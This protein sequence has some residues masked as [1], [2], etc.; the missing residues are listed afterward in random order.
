MAGLGEMSMLY[1]PSTRGFYAPGIHGDAVPADAVSITAARHRRLLALQAAGARISSGTDGRPRAQRAAGTRAAAIDAVKAEARRRIDAVA[2]L[3]R[4]LND[5]ADVPLMTA[6]QLL[7][8]D[9]RHA[10]IRAIRAA[11]DLIEA[12]IADMG[13]TELR[14]LDIA[15]DSRWPEPR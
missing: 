15:H 9:R 11:S 14:A 13:A 10:R 5:V 6:E 4:Q 1:S 7:E 3:W 2:P 12:A 8:R